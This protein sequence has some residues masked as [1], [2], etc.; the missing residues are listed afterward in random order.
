MDKLKFENICINVLLKS[1]KFKIDRS[2]D[3]IR[4]F[5]IPKSGWTEKDFLNLVVD[6]YY[7]CV[8]NN[9]SVNIFISKALENLKIYEPLTKLGN[10]RNISVTT[11]NSNDKIKHL[12]ADTLSSKIYTLLTE[13][14]NRGGK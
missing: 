7:I 6:I 1:E 13:L 5:R 9:G 10:L 2:Y 4:N 3:V 11:V 14:I 8:T 12:E